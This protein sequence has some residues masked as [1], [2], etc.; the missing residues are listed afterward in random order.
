MDNQ[1]ISRAQLIDLL[2]RLSAAAGEWLTVYL[3]PASVREHSER[4]VLS[5]RVDPRLLDAAKVIDD[6]T[7]QREAARNGTGLALFH[8]PESTYAIVPPFPSQQGGVVLGAPQVGPLRD[9]VEQPGRTA[10]VLVTWGAYVVALF[11]AAALVRYKKGTGHIHP[12]HRKGGSSSAR[13]ARRTE[14]QRAEFLR[15]VGGHID[16]EL[17]QERV[18]HIFFGGNRLVLG[19]LTKES[20]FL[21]EHRHLVSPRVLLVKKATLDTMDA[22]LSDA[23]SAVVLR[24]DRRPSEA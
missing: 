5:S 14:N 19:P 16:E 11:D 2:E 1:R 10:L 13:F 21:R 17:G 15:R 6:D 12:P 4:V 18:E 24:P 8:G 20:R 3:Q 9:S 23:Y 22:A 7:V